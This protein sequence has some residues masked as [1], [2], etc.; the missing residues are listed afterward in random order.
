M[1]E[2]EPR[3]IGVLL[4][5][6]LLYVQAILN[7]IAGVLYAIERNDFQVQVQ[8]GMTSRELSL[9]GFVLILAGFFF[10]WVAR[11]LGRGV[12]SA[13]WIITVVV[14][15]E[16]FAAM[17]ILLFMDGA[18]RNDLLAHGL[19]SIAILLLLHTDAANRYFDQRA[20]I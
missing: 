13:R 9:A 19:L 10:A 8:T 7:L 6:L 17:W 14:S 3:P 15:V 16:L 2:D 5:E 4:V 18:A 1:F 20:R 11:D 12:E